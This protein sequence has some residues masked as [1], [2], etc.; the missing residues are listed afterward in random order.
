MKL[1]EKYSDIQIARMVLNQGTIDEQIQDRKLLNEDFELREYVSNLKMHNILLEEEH[2]NN[3][4][5]NYTI[6]K[7]DR[8][9]DSNS[10]FASL[11]YE[12]IDDIFDK[13]KKPKGRV[14][15]FPTLLRSNYQYAVASVLLLLG[16]VYIYFVLQ[17]STLEVREQL[18]SHYNESKQYADDNKAIKEDTSFTVGQDFRI[19]FFENDFPFQSN[20]NSFIPK[21]KYEEQCK[22]YW[23]AW[24]FMSEK[25]YESA[26]NIFEKLWKELPEGVL[27]QKVAVGLMKSLLLTNNDD[28]LK[29]VVE[30]TIA[31]QEAYPEARKFANE[32]KSF[33]KL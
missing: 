20:L 3:L 31:E 6:E 9:F 14:I 30:K 25:N 22:Q 23:Q 24:Y 12:N 18:A 32:V 2:Y 5:E 8:Y 29:Q 4:K 17:K 28:R 19:K 21:N 26:L 27:H 13:R 15:Q 10:I 7:D 33:L 16:I 1:N 11:M